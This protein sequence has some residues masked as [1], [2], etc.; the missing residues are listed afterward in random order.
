MPRLT[1]PT[2]RFPTSLLWII[3]SLTAAILLVLIAVAGISAFVSERPSTSQ[4]DV[5]VARA[6][7]VLSVYGCGEV[8]IGSVEIQQ[9]SGV[10]GRLVWSAHQRRGVEPLR[11]LPI[12]SHI[13]G[14]AVRD[15]LEHPE[16]EL[17]VRRVLNGRGASLL[18]NYLVFR[19]ADLSNGS[20]VTTDGKIES[21]SAWLPNTT[22]C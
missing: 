3:L 13:R 16:Q 22:H 11:V 17:A 18:Q 10:G 20:I 9:G 5:G 8:G 6:H 2:R 1:A 14:Y 12:R 19:P 4:N 15:Y 21:L 7:G